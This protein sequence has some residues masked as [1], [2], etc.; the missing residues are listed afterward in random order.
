MSQAL[1]D[2]SFSRECPTQ[3]FLLLNEKK[4]KKKVEK[5]ANKKNV[6]FV[7]HFHI[8]RFLPM[9]SYFSFYHFSLKTAKN[10]KNVFFSLF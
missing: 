10:Q 2:P 7:L 9:R 6:F 5:Q 3:G 4:G 8:Y 1:D